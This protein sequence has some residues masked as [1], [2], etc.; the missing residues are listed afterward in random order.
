MPCKAAVRTLSIV[1]VLALAGLLGAGAASA[2]VVEWGANEFGQLGVNTDTGPETCGVVGTG[3][4]TAPV[5]VFLGPLR[6]FSAGYWHVA[7]LSETGLLLSWGENIWGELGNERTKDNYEEEP[8]EHK[9]VGAPEATC[10]KDPDIVENA[11]GHEVPKG[12]ELASVS[13]GVYYTLAVTKSGTV[14]GWGF[15]GTGELGDGQTGNGLVEPY[16]QY[17]PKPHFVCAVEHSAPCSGSGQVLEGATQVVTGYFAS[18]GLLSS[19]EVAVWGRADVGQLGVKPTDPSLEVCPAYLGDTSEHPCSTSPRLMTLPEKV[20][21][22]ATSWYGDYAVTEG[23][24]AYAWGEAGDPYATHLGTGHVQEIITEG[25]HKTYINPTPE[26]MPLP[27]GQVA[28]ISASVDG[29]IA[30]LK[31]GHVMTW[32]EGQALGTGSATSSSVPVEVPGVTGAVAVGAGTGMRA[33]LLSN[34]TVWTWGTN[35]AG[36]LGDQLPSTETYSPFPVPVV[37]LSEATSMSIGF[38]FAIA[39]GHLSSVPASPKVGSVSPTG[40]SVAGGTEVTITGTKLSG[41]TTVRF[42][43]EPATSFTVNSS[44]SITAIAPAHAAGTVDVTVITAGGASKR[45]TGDHYTYS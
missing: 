6:D 12:S 35:Y 41:A 31:N 4:S 39:Q 40:G 20:T 38:D 37:G 44:T 11:E 17:E 32:G 27:E 24:E 23:G 10:T 25:T 26:R 33:V 18:M 15:N 13:A 8:S 22:I 14:E 21:S 2:D 30:L 28:A 43:G 5:G 36:Q 7:A 3:C 16:E 1:A 45:K 9:C 29:G 34:G 42:G 19:G